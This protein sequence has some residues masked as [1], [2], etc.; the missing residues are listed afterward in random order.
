MGDSEITPSSD[1]DKAVRIDPPN[2]IDLLI[3]IIETLRSEQGCPWDRKQTPASL[4]IY[5]VEEVYELVEAIGSGRVEDICEE[6]GDVFFHVLFLARMF[7]ESGHFDIVDV[8]RGVT[9]KMIR[10]HPHVFGASQ[11]STVEGIRKQWKEIKRKEKK[12]PPGDSILD[13]IPGSLPALI[14]AYRVSERAA[15]VGFDW[16]GLEGVMKKTEEEWSEFNQAVARK[17]PSE[18]S[19]EMGDLLFT[20]VNVA[21]MARIHPE[22]ALAEST[23]KFEKRFRFMEKQLSTSGVS[24]ESAPRDELER[25]WEEAKKRD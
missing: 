24:I 7:Q 20:M 2:Q 17:Q 5:L 16:D 3:K 18:M 10:R 22:T 21:R 15:G 25:L 6:I 14:R 1:P 13:A 8:A 4:S 11:V 12:R 9:E 19:M 23:R